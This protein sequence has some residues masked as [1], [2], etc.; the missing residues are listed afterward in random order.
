[1]VENN[2]KFLDL[3]KRVTGK[4]YNNSEKL[5]I[6]SAKKA[7]L[8]SLCKKNGVYI[9]LNALKDGCNSIICQ[10]KNYKSGIGDKLFINEEETKALC[11]G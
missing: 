8:E 4:N 2:K 5:K 6:T 11:I 7:A 1:M 9:N 10:D 3:L